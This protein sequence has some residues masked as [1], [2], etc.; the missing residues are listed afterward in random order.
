M[1]KNTSKFKQNILLVIICVLALALVIVSRLYIKT[2]YDIKYTLINEKMMTL[3]DVGYYEYYD[4]DTGHWNIP[5]AAIQRAKEYFG[6]DVFETVYNASKQLYE[7]EL[8]RITADSDT[9]AAMR[10]SA[11][12]SVETDQIHP[13]NL[14][15]TL[16]LFEQES[17]RNSDKTIYRFT[18]YGSY[19]VACIVVE[20]DILG[21]KITFYNNYR[22]VQ[23]YQCRITKKDM[24]T[25]REGLDIEGMYNTANINLKEADDTGFDCIEMTVDGQYC[26]AMGYYFEDD[27]YEQF[28]NALDVLCSKT[29][30]I[31]VYDYI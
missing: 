13:S 17:I 1:E 31:N 15:E 23:K 8:S 7:D 14:A 24:K 29:L 6:E 9:M 20:E 30:N 21:G 10:V 12:Q 2:F 19:P 27:V 22:T 18:S 4:R 26:Y 25:F 28:Y 5:D 3:F 11:M 16:N